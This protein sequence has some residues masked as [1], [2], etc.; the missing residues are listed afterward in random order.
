MLDERNKLKYELK[1]A[2][3]NYDVKLSWVKSTKQKTICKSILNELLFLDFEQSFVAQYIY[4]SDSDTQRIFTMTSAYRSI[5]FN[6][7]RSSG[8]V[9]IIQC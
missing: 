3:N 6:L 5:L 8:P 1:I 4:I 7:S 9:L 2:Y